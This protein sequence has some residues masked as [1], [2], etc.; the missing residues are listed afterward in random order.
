MDIKRPP[1]SK[2]KKRIRNGALIVI[3]VAAL[4]GITYGLSKMK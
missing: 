3:G 4:G 1:K 2:I